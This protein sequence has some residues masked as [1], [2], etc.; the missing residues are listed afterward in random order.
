MSC[1]IVFFSQAITEHYLPDFS[2]LY[3]TYHV[4]GLTAFLCGAQSKFQVQTVRAQRTLYAFGPCQAGQIHHYVS[5]MFLVRDLGFGIDC[6]VSVFLCLLG[7][8]WPSAFPI[9]C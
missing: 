4:S 2:L 8:E 9:L 7:C 3:F 1:R 5:S 6:E